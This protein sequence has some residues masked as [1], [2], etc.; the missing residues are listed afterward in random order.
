MRGQPRNIPPGVHPNVLIDELPRPV[1]NIV[2]HNVDRLREVLELASEGIRLDA[3]VAPPVR[4]VTP[5][6]QA[7]MRRIPVEGLLRVCTCAN[8]PA[9]GIRVRLQPTIKAASR[10]QVES[11]RDGCP[12]MTDPVGQA[13]R[14]TY[15]I[16]PG[17][18]QKPADGV[19]GSAWQ[20]FR[21]SCCAHMVC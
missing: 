16:L 7:S 6:D 21:A 5:H 8:H 10:C 4:P 20:R 9:S 19:H 15:R 12:A 17:L 2:V 14:S 13:T 3:H 11:G 1:E 18:D